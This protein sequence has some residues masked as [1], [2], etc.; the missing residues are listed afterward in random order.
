M[1]LCSAHIFFV[2]IKSQF[3][4]NQIRTHEPIYS[5]HSQLIFQNSNSISFDNSQN[6]LKLNI[7]SDKVIYSDT[8]STFS[9]DNYTMEISIVI[10]SDWSDKSRSK[11]KEILVCL[12]I[13]KLLSKIINISINNV[14]LILKK[15]RLNNSSLEHL[16]YF[17]K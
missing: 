7:V 3:P 13:D 11:S 9:T 4:I 8:P 10:E 14:A 12:V 17:G 15:I 1:Q 5:R 6:V 16:K 2:N